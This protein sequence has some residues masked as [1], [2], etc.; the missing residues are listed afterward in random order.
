MTALVPG[1][2]VVHN[3]IKYSQDYFADWV[4]TV[5]GEVDRAGNGDW[6]D[7]VGGEVDWA[8]NGDWVDIVGLGRHGRRQSGLGC[9]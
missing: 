5:G 4:D 9:T 8:G 6:V 1:G 3:H 2:K 7:T